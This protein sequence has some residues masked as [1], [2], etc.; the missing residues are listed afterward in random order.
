MPAMR[1][2]TFASSANGSLYTMRR[3]ITSGRP[4]RTRSETEL[5][6]NEST[7]LVAALLRAFGIR[8]PRDSFSGETGSGK[9]MMFI[10]PDILIRFGVIV[11]GDR[12]N[13]TDDRNAPH[14]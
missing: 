14:G 9:V 7:S 6:F 2:Y 11:L 3:L 8:R 10:K 12:M 4:R 13:R 5:T 1:K